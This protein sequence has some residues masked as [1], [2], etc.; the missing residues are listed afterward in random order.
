MIC[1][2]AIPENESQRPCLQYGWGGDHRAGLGISSGVKRGLAIRSQQ[3]ED[4]IT[5]IHYPGEV[6][7]RQ[8][9]PPS[10]VIAHGL[11]CFVYG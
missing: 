10:V 7:V 4:L 11:V 1:L 5:G 6:V 8:H 2:T 3:R 9:D